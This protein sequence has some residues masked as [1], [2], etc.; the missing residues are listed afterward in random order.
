MARGRLPT[1][2]CRCIR[3]DLADPDRLFAVT[4]Q[5]AYRP[6]LPDGSR[7]RQRMMSF[8]TRLCDRCAAELI[9]QRQRS[10]D[11]RLVSVPT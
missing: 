9:P 5:R 1:S 4:L 10:G 8:A 7:P 3:C 2:A 6:R 11:K